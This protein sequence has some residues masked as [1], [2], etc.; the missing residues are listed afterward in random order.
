MRSKTGLTAVLQPVGTTVFVLTVCFALAVLAPCALADET[1]FPAVYL[2]NGGDQ[3]GYVEVVLHYTPLENGEYSYIY[4]VTNLSGFAGA[5]L[6]TFYF[7]SVEVSDVSSFHDP[8]A[9]PDGWGHY[10]GM[11]FVPDV[12]DIYTHSVSDP[13][14]GDDVVGVQFRW[15]ASSG[16]GL[17]YNEVGLFGFVSP[18]AYSELPIDPASAYVLS[19]YSNNT[20]RLYGPAPA[21]AQGKQGVPEW[22]SVMLALMGIGG[23]GLRFRRR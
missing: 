21:S 6:S 18:Y 3:T 2:K 11:Q 7:T 19:A 9:Q 17:D 16:T 8:W 13:T 23:V 10:A 4:W 22:S 1:I 14:T 15:D 5:E 20:E 12:P